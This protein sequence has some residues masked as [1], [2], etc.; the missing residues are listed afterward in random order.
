MLP[1]YG[2]RV[3]SDLGG[4]LGGFKNLE[5]AD[6]RANLGGLGAFKES[7]D[8]PSRAAW[9]VWWVGFSKWC[10]ALSSG[11]FLQPGPGSKHESSRNCMRALE[12]YI[13][14]HAESKYLG[15]FSIG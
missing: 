15:G 1:C 2:G 6:F 4:I 13:S 8:L 11:E 14:N 12:F 3:S 7:L 9:W 5:N 10:E